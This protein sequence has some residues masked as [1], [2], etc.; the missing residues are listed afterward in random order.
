MRIDNNKTN[1]AQANLKI[2]ETR[3]KKPTRVKR[4]ISYTIMIQH[5]NSK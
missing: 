1:K 2:Y 4:S 5:M 3:Q